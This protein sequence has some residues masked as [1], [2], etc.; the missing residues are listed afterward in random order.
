MPPLAFTPCQLL[1]ISSGLITT[2]EKAG[3][4]VEPYPLAL[5]LWLYS[6]F[7]PAVAK[8][9]IV[10][11]RTHDDYRPKRVQQPVCPKCSSDCVKRASR[12]SFERLMSVFYIYPFRCLPCGHRFRVL[13]WGVTY[14]KIELD[15]D[16][17]WRRRQKA[18]RQMKKSGGATSYRIKRG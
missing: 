9:Y 18:P 11:F 13:K 8:V 4:S 1:C 12:V 17:G 6:Y 7:P 16:I 10:S 2:Q 5:P 3:R 15:Q 14:T